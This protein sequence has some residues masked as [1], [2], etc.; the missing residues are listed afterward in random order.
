LIAPMIQDAKA[1]AVHA[2]AFGLEN[3]WMR[4]ID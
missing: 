3:A 4:L 2:A 1:V